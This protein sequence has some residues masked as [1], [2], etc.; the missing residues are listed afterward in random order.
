MLLDS[1][2]SSKLAVIHESD[3]PENASSHDHHEHQRCLRRVSLGLAD[4]A[5]DDHARRRPESLTDHDPSVGTP[6]SA[7]GGAPRVASSPLE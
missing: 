1:R 2:E 5:G 3:F 4:E 6:T 7:A